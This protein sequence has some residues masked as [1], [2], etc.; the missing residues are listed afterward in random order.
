MWLKRKCQY[1]QSKVDES[2][3]KDI[4]TF[5]RMMTDIRKGFLKK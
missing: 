2:R 3:N 1:I 4:N 5:W